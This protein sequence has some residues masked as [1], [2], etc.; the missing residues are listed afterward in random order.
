MHHVIVTLW[1]LWW[2][3]L[4][5]NFIFCIFV[6]ITKST[7]NVVKDWDFGKVI[8][9]AVYCYHVEHKVISSLYITNKL[10]IY[11]DDITTLYY[12]TGL[13]NCAGQLISLINWD[14]AVKIGV[15]DKNILPEFKVYELGIAAAD[16]L[17]GWIYGIAAVGLILDIPLAYKLVWFPGVIMIYHSLSFWFWVG[18]QNKSGHPTTSDSLR[19]GWTLLNFVTGILC[20]LIAW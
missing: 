10:C 19:V 16:V 15:A 1:A 20:I 14:L 13:W 9:G 11:C 12:I 18:N 3:F 8:K 7:E 5:E 4:A 17:L 2:F 6:F